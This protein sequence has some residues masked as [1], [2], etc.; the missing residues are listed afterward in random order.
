MICFFI[1]YFYFILLFILLLLISFFILPLCSLLIQ[2]RLVGWKDE[3]KKKG[4]FYVVK[5]YTHIPDPHLALPSNQMKGEM[6]TLE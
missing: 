1:L 3:K 2:V 5:I 6:R 4:A